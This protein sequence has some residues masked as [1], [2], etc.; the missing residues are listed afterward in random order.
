MIWQAPWPRSANGTVCKSTHWFR[1]TD[2]VCWLPN[3]SVGL[4]LYSAIH[5]SEYRQEFITMGGGDNAFTEK[6]TPANT[7]VLMDVLK[8]VQVKPLSLVNPKLRCGPFFVCMNGNQILFYVYQLA[9]LGGLPVPCLILCRKMS[10]WLNPSKIVITT[11]NRLPL[12]NV[13][14]HHDD[15]C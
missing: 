11:V 6:V 3:T 13:T 5:G 10:A 2:R 9:L 7:T 4:W 15:R 12:P 8:G 14:E 1:F